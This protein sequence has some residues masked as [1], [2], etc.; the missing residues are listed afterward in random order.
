MPKRHSPRIETVSSTPPAD[1][2]LK[3]YRTIRLSVLIGTA[4]VLAIS[5]VAIYFWHDYQEKLSAEKLLNQADELMAQDESKAYADAASLYFRYTQIKPDD[6]DAQVRLAE[7]YE[8]TASDASSIQRATDL[9]NEAIGLTRNEETR[10]KLRRSLVQLL[11]RQG[12]YYEA[13]T[14]SEKL[15][16]SDSV[17]EF[18]RA[19]LRALS[20]F[21]RYRAGDIPSED[22]AKL[23]GDLVNA[24][25]RAVALNPDPELVEPLTFLLEA[26]DPRLAIFPTTASDDPASIDNASKPGVAGEEKPQPLSREQR[27]AEA[28][29]L[30]ERMIAERPNDPM[31]FLV[32]YN[33]WQQQAKDSQRSD[34]PEYASDLAKAVELGPDN[35]TVRLFAG[36]DAYEKARAIQQTN[37]L[38]TLPSATEIPADTAPEMKAAVVQARQRYEEASTHY[39][40]VLDKI[41]AANSTALIGLGQS[42]VAL[43]NPDKAVELWQGAITKPREDQLAFHF[44]LAQLAVQRQKWGDAKSALADLDKD[45]ETLNL[46]SDRAQFEPLRRTVG[47][48]HAR[49]LVADDEQKYAD[50]IRILERVTAGQPSSEYETAEQS[51]AY[52]LAGLCHERLGRPDMAARALENSARLAAK[53]EVKAATYAAA[54]QA[55]ESSAA[56][57]NAVTAADQ[58]VKLIPNPESLF[59]LARLLTA[60]QAALPQSQQKWDRFNEI[61]NKLRSAEG[62]D[63]LTAAWRLDLLQADVGVFQAANADEAKAAVENV[64]Q[65][66]KDVEQKYPQDPVL[67]NRL[68]NVYEQLQHPEDADRALQVFQRVTTDPF[69]QKFAEVTLRFGRRQFTEAIAALDAIP[70][71]SATAAQEVDI[72]KTRARIMA[73]NGQAQ[74]ASELLKTL[75][76]NNPEDLSIARLRLEVVEQL[77]DPQA[78]AALEAE[79]LGDTHDDKSW[80][81]V[82]QLQ[83]LIADAK[84]EQD[85]GLL[86][87]FG[88]LGRLETARPEWYIVYALRGAAEEKRASFVPA[89]QQRP[90]LDLAARAYERAIALGDRTLGAQERLISVL[91]R[92]GRSDDAMTCLERIDRTLPLS[93]TLSE[94]AI[95]I[96][97]ENKQ[98]DRAEA[99]AKRAVE[100]R[101][102]D[103]LA[104]V[105]YGL[106]LL[107]VGKLDEAK[108]A[109]LEAL[110]VAPQDDQVWNGLFTFY[111]RTNDKVKARETLDQMLTQANMS[112]ERRASVKAQAFESLEDDAQADVAYREAYKSFPENERIR[113]RL[114]QFYGNRLTSS[115]FPKAPAID[116]LNDI[117]TRYPRDLQAKQTLM[118]MLANAGG[119]EYRSALEMLQKSSAQDVA[120]RRMEAYL[121]F[122]RDGEDNLARAKAILD[123]I[124]TSLSAEPNDHLLLA[125]ILERQGD[126]ATARSNLAKL[127]EQFPPNLP[128][129]FAFTEFLIRQRDLKEAERVFGLLEQQVGSALNFSVLELKARLLVAQ[130]RTASV[131]E[132]IDPILQ[133]Q[134]DAL[135]VGRKADKAKLAGQAGDLYA[136]LDLYAPAEVWYRR[137][138]ELDPTQIAPLATCLAKMNRLPDA[139]AICEGALAGLGA[140][141]TASAITDVLTTGKPATADYERAEPILSA[142]VQAAANDPNLLLSIANVR[143]IQ[144][145]LDDAISL[146]EK[147]VQLAPKNVL[148]LNNLAMI[149]SERPDQRAKAIQCID[150]ALDITGPRPDLHDTK[151]AILLYDN[152]PQEALDLLTKVNGPAANSPIIQFHLAAAYFGTKDLQK[153][154]KLYSAALANGLENQ[155]LT[156]SD[157]QL[158][159]SMKALLKPQ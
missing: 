51:Q 28:V 56:I 159:A 44:Y 69:A 2:D 12:A 58:A 50:A 5:G 86:E 14:A 59:L 1:T 129:L 11:L 79:L 76:A 9:L 109:L 32:R 45:I 135:T 33:Y 81:Q 41:D 84:S 98:A 100:M 113:A 21:G 125:R 72:T 74:Q 111:V 134:Y 71:A 29:A 96:A 30:I 139:L 16:T 110:Q 95:N 24:L 149:L 83:R 120:D 138:F 23:T 115:A 55:W 63:L 127:S 137:L 104:R 70:E 8:K 43:G 22:F 157:R 37:A 40:H 34:I 102:N 116:A 124:V 148:A 66:A 49:V 133:R 89:D 73:A 103:S 10:N 99:I 19:R 119:N 68:I 101:P 75:A 42:A 130:G 4:L 121:L 20:L 123:P 107:N 64:Y 93:R 15:V 128:A 62:T 39:Q 145:R 47:L 61:V 94:I 140:P 151:A 36:N 142:A 6:I 18:T 67:L 87:A 141:A 143:L 78:R 77:D 158:M 65:V 147:V 122:Q 152:K 53:P 85:R 52:R 156:Q 88:L 132:Q 144:G 97:M 105:W 25:R 48:M 154:E 80:A 106:V 27:I 60:Q 7:A 90:I 92:A 131:A 31:A 136:K 82:L 118:S 112:P 26:E 57:E 38:E 114:V 146:L 13:A 108:R 91:Y 54:A 46:R 150:Q 3:T 126:V 17:D 117:V 35:L 153:A 155:V